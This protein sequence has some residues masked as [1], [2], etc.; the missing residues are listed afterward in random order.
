MGLQVPPPSSQEGCLEFPAH[1]AR[2]DI[3]SRFESTKNEFQSHFGPNSMEDA[4]GLGCHIPPFNDRKEADHVRIKVARPREYNGQGV[5][6]RRN[7]GPDCP[8]H[9]VIGGQ[10]HPRRTNQRQRTGRR[11]EPTPAHAD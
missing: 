5:H 4:I 10:L 6:G 1:L 9:H 8:G 2:Y 7:R 11:T 3:L